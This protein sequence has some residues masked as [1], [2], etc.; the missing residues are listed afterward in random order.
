MAL[1]W[2]DEDWAF[3]PKGSGQRL[4]E[5]EESIF[6]KLFASVKAAFGSMGDTVEEAAPEETWQ[7]PMP[8][9]PLE[10]YYP[11]PAPEYIPEAP[12]TTGFEDE[13]AIGAPA[14]EDGAPST[15]FSGSD[16]PEFGMQ[17]PS[18]IEDLLNSIVGFRDRLSAGVTGDPWQDVEDLRSIAP[19]D[20]APTF[21]LPTA[22]EL[23]APDDQWGLPAVQ[24]DEPIDPNS[25]S[26]AERIG[27]L[28]SQ[29]PRR[30]VQDFEDIP[31]SVLS[32]VRQPEV[33][34]DFFGNP[35]YTLNEDTGQYDEQV[36]PAVGENG[37]FGSFVGNTLLK[38]V[39]G[40]GKALNAAQEYGTGPALVMA[41][42]WMQGIS[43]Y[44]HDS[45][46]VGERY[47]DAVE[48]NRKIVSGEVPLIPAAPDWV[49]PL[50]GAA[51]QA[52]TNPLSY[53]GPAA[54]AKAIP[55]AAPGAPIL[56][57]LLDSGGIGASI[58]GNVGAVGAGE[59][60]DAAG[61][62]N[63]YVNMLIQLAGGVVGGVGGAL[64]PTAASLGKRGAVAALNA[65]LSLP[66]LLP[67][68]PPG[69]GLQF[70]MANADAGMPFSAGVLDNS[71][72]MPN[73]LFSDR[74][75]GIENNFDESWPT[76]KAGRK[77]SG[78]NSVPPSAVP[79]PVEPIVAKWLQDKSVAPDDL[80]PL[81]GIAQEQIGNRANVDA[82]RSQFRVSQADS[83]NIEYKRVL[84][85]TGDPNLADMAGKAKAAIEMDKV[86]D[87][88]ITPEQ[89]IAAHA[90]V[91]DIYQAQPVGTWEMKSMEAHRIIN[92]M[93][94][95]ERLQ[96]AEQDF[97]VQLFG[98]PESP[99]AKVVK[100]D[101]PELATDF[102]T[103]P[104]RAR[105]P[106][107][108]PFEGME[109]VPMPKVQDQPQVP[110]T[111][112]S[113]SG[114]RKVVP[115]D[116]LFKTR[117]NYDP[118][119]QFN[120][121]DPNSIFT[122][123]QQVSDIPDDLKGILGGKQASLFNYE[124]LMGKPGAAI[125]T[126]LA[127][128]RAKFTGIS[129]DETTT[130]AKVSG[131]VDNKYAS[132]LIDQRRRLEGMLQH[133]GIG[134]VS[135]EERAAL[136]AKFGSKPRIYHEALL[137]AEQ[138]T[139]KR[140][141]TLADE[142]TKRIL[143]E[144]FAGNTPAKV[145]AALDA[146]TAPPSTAFGAALK[147]NRLWRNT[148]FGIFDVGSIL[149]QGL[150]SAT[151][152]PQ[153]AI[154]YVNQ[155]LEAVGAPHVNVYSSVDEGLER[156]RAGGRPGQLTGPVTSPLSNDGTLLSPVLRKLSESKPDNPVLKKAGDVTY[157]L[158]TEINRI[159]DK[160]NDFQFGKMMGAQNRAIYEGNMVIAKLAE[161]IGLPIKADDMSTKEA[162][163]RL[164]NAATSRG[165]MAQTANRRAAEEIAM[166]SPGMRRAQADLILVGANF[167][168][169]TASAADRLAASMA[170][171]GTATAVATAFALDKS[172]DEFS[173]D[174]NPF[175]GGFGKATMNL[176]GSGRNVVVDLFP[177]RQVQEAIAQAF[178]NVASGDPAQFA[179]DI[180]D[181]F[182]KGASPVGRSMLNAIGVGFDPKNGVHWFDYPDGGNA[183]DNIMN[184]APLPPGISQFL[185][186]QNEDDP[187]QVP[188]QT[189]INFI[190]GNTYYESKFDAAAR[191][192]SKA[193]LL[194]DANGNP[195]TIDQYRDL[196]EYPLARKLLLEA[197][198]QILDYDQAPAT[199]LVSQLI[200]QQNAFKQNTIAAYENGD[201]KNGDFKD[202]LREHN[203]TIGKLA[204]A[205]VAEAK[206]HEGEEWSWLDGYYSTFVTDPASG[207]LD[208]DA[209]EAAQNAFWTSLGDREPVARKYIYAYSD[210]GDSAPEKAYH[211]DLR[212]LNGF[213]PETGKPII[214]KDGNPLPSYYDLR[215]K[216][217]LSQVLPNEESKKI[218][219]DAREWFERKLVENPPPAGVK[220]KM[221]TADEI[222]K[223]Y[224]QQELGIAPTDPRV[225]DVIAYGKDKYENP[226]FTKYAAD[227]QDW[228]AWQDDNLSWSTMQLIRSK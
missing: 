227:H 58:G 64:T 100:P 176:P 180:G 36:N 37:D 85:L 84:D 57:S 155:M 102:Y 19:V 221:P 174:L 173:I 63:P 198:P 150:A 90:F 170:I 168:N 215:D 71:A 120:K 117:E 206:Q 190:G 53:F 223:A 91:N 86:V 23:Q 47:G 142:A 32:K 195:L 55:E 33:M 81:A 191:E 163:M 144:Q 98:A 65:D 188:Y 145:K 83:Y 204:S 125:D 187:T 194:K 224:M 110:S 42:D 181:Y 12:M 112:L 209:T 92:K 60:A 167:M 222:R 212:R 113:E 21:T 76:P 202:Q 25:P 29:G 51:Y 8:E 157:K 156:I 146:G 226:E 38:T 61:I 15:M 127:D 96:P 62:D 39:G 3:G 2:G 114:L 68:P 175:N 80:N 138:R 116:P 193:G 77:S 214:G 131:N 40:V 88:T 179:T 31:G 82:A 141:D 143:D 10:T 147:F 119:A 16:V 149:Q 189:I 169:P 14:A 108:K 164:A 203:T 205:I 161:K 178:S 201:I 52:G 48:Q 135:N 186:G 192:M 151:S 41:S 128:T 210:I 139:K 73:V 197:N 118:A 6:D 153:A 27:N 211:D 152:A 121:N 69:G 123:G 225:F 56:Q 219:D 95:G 34:T 11:E 35:K 5:D 94:G 44:N 196:A 79:E 45:R 49:D 182:V 105:D 185:N 22:P 20:E 1:I 154:G 24:D 160:L 213:D 103:G 72:E 17:Q 130:L 126:W 18:I 107:W 97:A 218:Q 99:I 134:V 54:A 109:D 183:K 177:Q 184:I 172:T 93:Q 78:G 159:G 166:L 124:S 133:E 26:I 199:A 216:R 43:P 74:T 220:V 13:Y 46:S 59:L 158:D 104:I 106:L 111:G 28:L 148:M 217:Y 50:V 136:S 140:L 132:T 87:A 162:M 9:G 207:L 30:V 137:E 89:A 122:P 4:E 208:Q 129:P 70:A 75:P 200:D 101:A 115:D 67:P 228:L 66:N 171:A 7:E 165:Q